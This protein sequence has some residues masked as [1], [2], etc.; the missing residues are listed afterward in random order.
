[1]LYLVSLELRWL[2]YTKD[3]NRRSAPT[4]APPLSRK[5]CR[6]DR[7]RKN[8]PASVP[9]THMR[10]WVSKNQPATHR[11][12]WISRKNQP[13]SRPEIHR[14]TWVSKSQPATHRRTWVSKS[15]PASVTPLPALTLPE[16][17]ARD[18]RPIHLTPYKIER[19]KSSQVMWAAGLYPCHCHCRC[20]RYPCCCRQGMQQG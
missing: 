17:S 4:L 9:A 15:Q 3:R 10:K 1:M 12:M 5:G 19:V 13:T 8:Q 14:R 18:T 7:C 16:K 11:R 20:H 2:L 6:A